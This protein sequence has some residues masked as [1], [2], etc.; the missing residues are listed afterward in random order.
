MMATST[1]SSIISRVRRDLTLGRVLQAAL[2]FAL[3]FCFLSGA[4]DN[5]RFISLL[6]IGSLWF[7]MGLNSARGSRTAAESPSLIASGQ[8][9]AAEKNIEQ[10]VR[11]FSLFRTVKLQALHHLAVLRHAQRRWQES[12][13]FAQALLSQRLGALQPISRPTRLLLADSL[14]EM[15][16]LRGAYFA[17]NGLHQEHLTL[18]ESMSLL[19]VQL[20][21]SARVGA[22][23]AMMQ[24]WMAKV[25]LAE[26]MPASAS[27]RAQGYL[28]LAAIKVRRDDVAAWLR[29]RA[30]LLA[31][32]TRL[33]EERPLLAEVWPRKIQNVAAPA[34]SNTES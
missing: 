16:D 26:L 5:V 10:T 28:A 12:A 8:F 29:Q 7:W 31:D 22:W 21:Y 18:P 24:N 6:A 13:V 32:V 30:E 33:A 4:G 1:A 34:E 17:L 14:L 25:R 2:S 20:D 11:S 27:A 15:N 3:V 19:A 9:D 23:Q